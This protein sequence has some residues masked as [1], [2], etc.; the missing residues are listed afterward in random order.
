MRVLIRLTALL[1]QNMVVNFVTVG[2]VADLTIKDVVQRTKL[3][4]PKKP[5]AQLTLAPAVLGGAVDRIPKISEALELFWDLSK[6]DVREKTADELRRWRNPRLK[7]FK[8]FINVVGDKSVSKLTAD[9]MLNFREWL[10]ERIEGG[11]SVSSTNKDL[12]HVSSV[13]KKV[14]KMKRLN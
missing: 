9:D 2:N 12:I 6:P 1:A 11:L 8:N 10:F 13:L 14:N 3:V 5:Q 4:Q 7:A